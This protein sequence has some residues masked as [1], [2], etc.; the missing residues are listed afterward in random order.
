M[1]RRVVIEGGVLGTE[2]GPLRADLVLDGERIAALT[3]DASD[4]A[5]EAR[6]DARGKL[7][8]PG[9]IDVHTH[10]REP[11]TPQVEG[12][13]TGSRGAIA[14]GITCVVEMPQATPVSSQGAHIEAKVLAAG[15][16]SIIDFALWGAAINQDIEQIDEMVE[17]GVVGIK[18]FMAGSSPGFPTISDANLLAVFERLADSGIPYGLH[19]ENDALLQSG[20][21]GLKAAGRRDPL[22]HAES[23][24]PVVELEAINRALFFAEYTGGYAYICHVSTAG[25]FALIEQARARGV[26]VRGETCPQYLLLDETDLERLRGFGRCAPPLRGPEDVEGLWH[27]LAEGVVDLISSDHCGYSVESKAAGEDDIWQAPLG[28]SGVQTMFPAVLDAMLNQRAL[29]LADFVRLTSA[30]P[31]K[32][33]SLYPRKGALLPGSDADVVIYDLQAP[34][35]VRGED[36]LHRNKWTP[37]E[38]KRINARVVRTIVRGRTVYEWDG[39][40]RVRGERG[41]G[42][43]L[44]RGYGAG[45]EAFAGAGGGYDE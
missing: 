10:F 4:V 37:F 32:I 39:E 41:W 1:A 45:L 22:A 9:G 13:H 19:A 17:A 23:R 12:F 31:A 28:L 33:F 24:P 6:I 25:G 36:M 20:I 2:A 18:S 34:W 15:R 7:V 43:F 16:E 38:G 14:G 5:A 40:H 42:K 26:Q 21:A 11:N 27:Y 44:R 29:E 35:T 3:L 30:N 8:L